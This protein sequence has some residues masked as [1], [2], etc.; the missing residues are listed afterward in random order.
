LF[1]VQLMVQATGVW[2]RRHAA[3]YLAGVRYIAR[4]FGH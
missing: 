2:V 3:A 4:G 1:E